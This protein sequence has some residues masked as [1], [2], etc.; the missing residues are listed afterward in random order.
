L[1]WWAREAAAGEIS[2]ERLVD[3]ALGEGEV[4]DFFARGS[5]AMVIWW[6]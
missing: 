1:R 5:F 4:L 3:R 6:R 2:D